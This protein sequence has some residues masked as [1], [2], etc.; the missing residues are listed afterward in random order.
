MV[1]LLQAEISDA[2]SGAV[3]IHGMDHA[4]ITELIGC[5]WLNAGGKTHCRQDSTP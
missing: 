2:E 3:T 4:N 1:D 5:G